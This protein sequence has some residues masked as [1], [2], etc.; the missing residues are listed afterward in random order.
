MHNHIQKLNIK[1]PY[2]A[3]N[4]ETYIKHSTAR[5]SHLQKS[6]FMNFYCEETL[7]SKTQKTIHSL[8]KAQYIFDLDTEI[9]K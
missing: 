9:F 2:I 6:R 5:I 4:S 8:Q 3:L 7:C 1:K